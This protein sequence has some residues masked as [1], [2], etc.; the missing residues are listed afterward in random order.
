MREPKLT[1]LT[2]DEK[3]T[4]QIRV[5]MAKARKIKITINVDQDSLALLRAKS[6]QT[7]IPYQRLLNQLLRRSLQEDKETESRL[8]RL[9]RE[10]K[11]LKRR[12][13]A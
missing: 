5:K 1:D 13:V 3:S 10:M 8:D 12:S 4:G 2:V 11:R 6:A 9:E 7:G